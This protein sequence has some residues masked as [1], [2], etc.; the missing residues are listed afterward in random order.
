VAVSSGGLLLVSCGLF[1]FSFGAPVVSEIVL[2]FRLPLTSC[3]DSRLSLSSLLLLLFL[4]RLLLGL[5]LCLLL[6]L[7][8]NS[9]VVAIRVVAACMLLGVVS[10][11]RMKLCAV[12]DV[13]VRLVTEFLVHTD[14]IY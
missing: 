3:Q 6:L 7:L 14:T 5:R 10:A 9:V 11:V 1:F 13:Y 4:R 12:S 8:S 2:L